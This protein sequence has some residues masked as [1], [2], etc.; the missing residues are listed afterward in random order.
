METTTELLPIT[1]IPADPGQAAGEANEGAST[2]TETET[3]P[4]GSIGSET[5]SPGSAGSWP[6]PPSSEGPPPPPPPPPGS[7]G[8]PPPPPPPPAA[9][10]PKLL[11]RDPH[12]RILGGVAAGIADYL[13]IDAVIVR[14]AFVALVLLGGTGILLYLAAWLLIPEGET[15]RNIAQDFMERRPRR[16][17][18]LVLIIGVVLAAI[19]LSGIFSNGPWWPHWN[20][21]FGFFF[22]VVALALAV[23]LL[24]GS[25]G[26]RSAGSRLGWL[27][28]IL[29][30][31]I[32]AVAAVVAATVFSIEALSGVPLRG[33]IG[34]S[35]WTPTAVAQVHSK[36]RLAVGNLVVDLRNVSFPAGTRDVTASVGIGHLLVELPAGPT[37]SVT[38]K[39]GMGDVQVFGNSRFGSISTSQTAAARGGDPGDRAHIVLD[40]E[41]GV[42][43]V[44]VE[45]A[46][47]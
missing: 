18:I 9:G 47:P 45:R 39:S 31:T 13:G 33:G 42:G 5:G 6:E 15:H 10:G 32:A 20:Y 14:I 23:I 34:D 25:G 28:V 43:Q 3:E 8:P 19:A 21:G 1:D 30:V 41:T 27:A 29:L 36:Y 11:R 22:S 12:N 4:P 38:A 16:R 44:Q 40:A 37:V 2:A 17:N 46:S 26:N 24:A 35:Q 7:E